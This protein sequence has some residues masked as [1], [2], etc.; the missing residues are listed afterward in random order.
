MKWFCLIALASFILVTARLAGAPAIIPR[1]RP[2]S[3][4]SVHSWHKMAAATDDSDAYAQAVFKASGRSYGSRLTVRATSRASI[5][6]HIDCARG[7]D[8]ENRSFSLRLRHGRAR[9][10]TPLIGG[11]CNYSVSA[12]LAKGGNVEIGLY[13]LR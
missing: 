13:V 7:V 5:S 12:V 6:G 4:A 11:Q 2:A 9:I 10:P 8:N 3:A 1:S